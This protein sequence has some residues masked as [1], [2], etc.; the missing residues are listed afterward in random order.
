[1]RDLFALDFGHTTPA[2]AEL[3]ADTAASAILAYV[4][5]VTAGGSGWLP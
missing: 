2:G 5:T 4:E 1:M 3:I